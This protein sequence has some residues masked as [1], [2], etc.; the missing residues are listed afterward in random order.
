MSSQVDAERHE[1]IFSELKK[2]RLFS[3]RKASSICMRIYHRTI[4]MSIC[5]FV[6]FHVIRMCIHSV[7][8]LRGL[9]QSPPGVIHVGYTSHVFLR[10]PEE[11]NHAYLYTPSI[12]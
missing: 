8:L 1:E 4:L 3:K 6:L 12:F 5:V 7:F 11:V 9:Q 2:L 10:G